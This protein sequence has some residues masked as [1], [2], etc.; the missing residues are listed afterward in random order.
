MRV[1]TKDMYNSTSS[2]SKE[3]KKNKS[4]RMLTIYDCLKNG[5][6]IN[7]LE[8]SDEFGVSKRTIQ[9][10]ID[11]IRAYFAEQRITGADNFVIIFDKRSNRFYLE[12]EKIMFE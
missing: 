3:V 4:F 6:G 5:T 12:R 1:Q 9:R 2:I 7:K 10:D 11:D 8:I